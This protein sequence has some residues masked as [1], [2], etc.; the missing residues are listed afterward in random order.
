MY[1]PFTVEELKD[2]DLEHLIALQQRYHQAAGDAMRDGT[3][4]EIEGLLRI[5]DSVEWELSR[6]TGIPLR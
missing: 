2:F 4:W 3:A 1:E 6:R 5:A